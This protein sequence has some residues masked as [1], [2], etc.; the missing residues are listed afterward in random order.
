MKY[1]HIA[2]C[3]FNRA[4]MITENKLGVI[5]HV[6]SQQSGF[7]IN[8]GLFVPTNDA[9]EVGH[10]ER[11]YTGTGYRVKDGLA[12]IGIYGPLMHRRLAG[13]FP[14]GGPT[15]YGEIRAS[16]DLAME[17]DAVKGIVLEIDSPGGEVSG[18]FDL[19]EH[20]RNSRSIKPVTAVVNESAYSAAYLLA[21]ATD[22][23]I[24]PRTGGVGSV[25]VIAT[26]A[27]FSRRN[28]KKGITV[29]HVF[30]GDRKADYS[31][32]HPLSDEAMVL[33]QE[34]VNENYQLFVETVAR[35]RNMSVQ[36]VINTQAGTYEGQ[37]A[38]DIGFADE[39]LAVDQAITGATKQ[40]GSRLITATAA[41][42]AKTKELHMTEQ[43][44]R[45]KHPDLVAGIEEKARQG[46]ITQADADS[47]KQQ[48]V[49]AENERV[50]TLVTAAVGEETGKKIA[51][52]SAKG[53]TA[54][55]LTALGI[56]LSATGQ[57]TEQGQMLEAITN[58]A[59]KGVKGG[60]KA[61]QQQPATIDTNAIYENRRN[62]IAGK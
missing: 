3:L 17:D 16:F 8:G 44:L 39:V 43:E 46:M 6:F 20:I 33:L 24:L 37:K 7:E 54:E 10:R 4:L 28:D 40:I 12:I 14:S 58:A 19:A 42:G 9:R 1:L 26:H 34:S 45:E 18:V 31:P 27:D 5:Q 13:E 56:D 60:V 41:T 15:T 22:K 53:L 30:A 38:I 62:Q 59:S 23:I 35:Y 50:M 29:T 25:G 57:Q 61:Q 36:D 52:A 48:A 11:S 32:H 51:A 2:D 21:S 55:D 49:T 47:A